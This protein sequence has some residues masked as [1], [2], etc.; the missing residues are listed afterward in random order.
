MKQIE[1]MANRV[2]ADAACEWIFAHTSAVWPRRVLARMKE[3]PPF[4]PR[5]T[6][7]V[8]S[9][10]PLAIMDTPPGNLQIE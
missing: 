2:H 10:D 7:I 3:D 8:V 6:T 4:D 1:H 5:Q 9:A